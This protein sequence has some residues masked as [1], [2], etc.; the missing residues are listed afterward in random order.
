MS[1]SYEMHVISHSHWD[2][3]WRYSFAEYRL[4]LIAM[5]D[6]LLEILDT[7]PDYKYYHLDAQ[8]SLVED[9]L[10]IRPENRKKIEHYAKQGRILIGPWYTLPE[11]FLISGESLVRNLML[12]H[13]IAT[14]LG[15]VMKVGYMPTSCGQI[16]Q[17]PPYPPYVGLPEPIEKMP[18]PSPKNRTTLG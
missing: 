15:R 16:S 10:E 11:E 17:L 9:Y 12:G 4:Q 2:R 7:R 13:K 6:R 5:M 1:E 14:K 3:E 18:S 8:T